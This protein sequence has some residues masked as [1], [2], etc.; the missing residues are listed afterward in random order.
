M[1]NGWSHSSQNETC[2]RPVSNFNYLAVA[3][4]QLANMLTAVSSRAKPKITVNET[5]AGHNINKVN[6]NNGRSTT[7]VGHTVPPKRF[8]AQSSLDTAQYLS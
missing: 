7:I 2:I 4:I 1:L 5:F 3:E 8:R 6:V